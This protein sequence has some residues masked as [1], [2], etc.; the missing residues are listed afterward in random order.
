V[1]EEDTVDRYCSY[2]WNNG[3]HLK[4]LCCAL[5]SQRDR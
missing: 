4:T 3:I 5:C 2:I 1:E